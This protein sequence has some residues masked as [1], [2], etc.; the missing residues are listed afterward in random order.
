MLKP[1]RKPG[2][3]YVIH[4]S[5][6]WAI[7]VIIV[8][9]GVLK[10]W[11]V[12]ADKAPSRVLYSRGGDTRVVQKVPS[13]SKKKKKKKKS[14]SYICLSDFSVFKISHENSFVK[15][16]TEKGW[17]FQN[18]SESLI[19]SALDLDLFKR[20]LYFE[21]GRSTKRFVFF[22]FIYLFV[23]NKLKKYKSLRGPTYIYIYIYIYIV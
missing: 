4:I 9:D 7:L 5:Y 2:W 12:K 13:L 19:L 11:C 6:I 14:H 3:L 17:T 21:T 10:W 18:S 16:Q 20:F 15:T 1:G 22:G 8:S 23:M